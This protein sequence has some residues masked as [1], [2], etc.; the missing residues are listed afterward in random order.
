SKESHSHALKELLDS[1]TSRALRG[2]TPQ[3]P[4]PAAMLTC[5]EFMGN[6]ASRLAHVVCD[7]FI[8]NSRLEGSTPSQTISWLLENL[9][10]F[11]GI[12]PLLIADLQSY[13]GRASDITPGADPV[14]LATKYAREIKALHADQRLL[15][16]GGWIEHP[17]GHFMLY[18]F[19][20]ESSSN[21]TFNIYNS[22]AGSNTFHTLL[23]SRGKELISP[24][25][26]FKNI[27][28]ETLFMGDANNHG[29]IQALLEMQTA[30]RHLTATENASL[31]YNDIIL[32]NLRPFMDKAAASQDFATPQRA[33]TCGYSGLI[34]FLRS[35][36]PSI[37]TFKEFQIHAKVRE[38]TKAFTQISDLSDSGKSGFATRY[39]L[40]K[41]AEWLQSRLIKA[42]AKAPDPKFLQHIATVNFILEDV[43][44]KN[45]A[46]EVLLKD[47]STSSEI[48]LYRAERLLP[49]TPPR[50]M[51]RALTPGILPLKPTPQPISSLAGAVPIFQTFKGA[52]PE[53]AKTWAVLFVKSLPMPQALPPEEA[54]IALMNHAQNLF[55]ILVES[56]KPI[57]TATFEQK[58]ALFKLY[59]LQ[60]ALAVAIDRRGPQ[61][62]FIS[63]FACHHLVEEKIDSLRAMDEEARLEYLSLREYFETFNAGKSYFAIGLNPADEQ[64][65]HYYRELLAHF[66]S[67]LSY[68]R[69]NIAEEKSYAFIVG[70]AKTYALPEKSTHL[71]SNSGER[72]KAV[73]TH[74]G[75]ESFYL[76]RESSLRVY[77]FLS[78]N[79][80][81]T[82]DLRSYV[83]PSNPTKPAFKYTE[84]H[85]SSEKS[86][87]ASF[88]SRR[89]DLIRPLTSPLSEESE[90]AYLEEISPSQYRPEEINPLMSE[91]LRAA[92]S[93]KLSCHLL[94]EAATN[95]LPLFSHKIVCEFFEALFFDP[96]RRL[97]RDKL[98]E[99]LRDDPA[100]IAL[101]Q[102][103]V[104][105]GVKLFLTKRH[106]QPDLAPL[107]TIL[108]FGKRLSLLQNELGLP[109]TADFPLLNQVIADLDRR[110]ETFTSLPKGARFFLEQLKL[111]TLLFSE[112]P[113]DPIHFCASWVRYNWL[114]RSNN[115]SYQDS[116]L[117]TI[118]FRRCYNE[119][120]KITAL[121]DK[122]AFIKALLAQLQLP[123]PPEPIAYTPPLLFTSGPWRAD[124]IN[125]SIGGIQ[126][127]IAPQFIQVPQFQSFFGTEPLTFH[128]TMHGTEFDHPKGHFMINRHPGDASF[129]DHLYAD[130]KEFGIGHYQQR[131][132]LTL[133]LPEGLI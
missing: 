47:I 96:K 22:G 81:P 13:A 91:M 51:L 89:N 79:N 84:D 122:D 61:P 12:S 118:L 70:A 99:L 16:P 54:S 88:F 3:L 97:N 40:Q 32:S 46:S 132:H 111:Q 60:H 116:P 121:S 119:L 62:P 100:F 56:Y 127:E 30:G 131:T 57:G 29:F 72:T 124:L 80:S 7:G 92:R 115:G 14:A 107:F 21:Y 17:F 20:K 105:E 23:Y 108:D 36:M 74:E 102:K 35:Q 38:L 8:R 26:S 106:A 73:F 63:N 123:I 10:A 77:N 48:T 5:E 110:M 58:V 126:A 27:P 86:F 64:T 103:F 11:P 94:I 78:A 109:Q 117:R 53:L 68:F 85:L 69:D 18:E 28:L 98:T 25:L 101:A 33:G 128:Y 9:E 42:Y 130:F 129:I 67:I 59:S 50:N 41:G 113:P 83:N 1:K 82:S 66:P 65:D 2:F 15:L 34:A 112:G 76:L 90:A 31:I 4:T 55:K 6:G 71:D 37:E 93:E 45:I 87:H 125:C 95:N 24:L 19:R 75:L 104:E 49:Y 114:L 120:Q 44:E 39:L 52:N 43:K 133:V